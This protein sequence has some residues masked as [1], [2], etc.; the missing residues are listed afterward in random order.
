MTDVYS[1]WPAG[2]SFFSADK[3]GIPEEHR[4]PA[5]A[6]RKRNPNRLSP[7]IFSLLML[8]A[9][10]SLYL[11]LAILSGAGNLTSFIRLAPQAF[12][13]IFA[14]A[15][16][17]AAVCGSFLV[18]LLL[19]S[20]RH[21]NELERS[22]RDLF[23]RSGISL[24][25]ED[26]TAVAEAILALKRAGVHDMRAYFAANPNLE[27]ELRKQVIVLDVN[28]FTVKMLGGEDKRPFL[29][30]LD[31]ILPQTDQTF[32][33]W[34][35]AFAADVPFFRSETHIIRPDGKAID[36]LFTASLPRDFEGF[37][38]IIISVWDI[39]SFKNAQS[40]LAEA[41]KEL[42][43]TSRV[44]TIG[45]LTASIAHEV[46]SPLAAIIANAEASQ[47]WLERPNPNLHEASSAV[48]NIIDAATRAHE[49]VVRT[50]GFL[51]NAP[52]KI[53]S[54]DLIPTV[55]DAAQIIERE[56]RAL[57]VSLHLDFDSELP[58][59]RADPIQIQQVLVNLM[60]NGI[61]AMS[62]ND[63]SRDLTVSIRHTVDEV[64]VAV[65]D[66]GEGIPAEQLSY[67]FD[68]FYTGKPNGMGMG[69]A[70]CRTCIE[71]HS[72]QIGVESKL[73]SGTTLY[74]T[75]PI[76]TLT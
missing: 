26:W 34:L 60:L 68:A 32:V 54:V 71:A 64:R 1:R 51:S 52:R 75:L 6:V 22:N 63:G 23:E 57:Q 55:R 72:G 11:I 15:T 40:R 44:L 30:P 29:G 48:S 37:R 27:R 58:F 7:T 10:F 43:R 39:T 49:V 9:L 38:S 74:F 53:I 2:S 12:A 62:K 19:R 73:G 45:A 69:L 66:Q 8:L 16:L 13:D 46:S 56:I 67:I 3:S 14:V 41:E 20:R 33:E 65:I 76:S 47:R 31:N 24:W 42:A 59:V 25:N 18:I 70:I 61:Q 17:V 28:E 4:L 5:W 36:T 50:N 35:I 21:E